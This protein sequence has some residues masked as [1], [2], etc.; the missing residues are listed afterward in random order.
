MNTFDSIGFNFDMLLCHTCMLRNYKSALTSRLRY[1]F[2]KV[3]K[4]KSGS[5]LDKYGR[6]KYERP[7]KITFL[8]RSVLCT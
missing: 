1:E 2:G 3:E 4:W 5:L 6:F 8:T 7:H